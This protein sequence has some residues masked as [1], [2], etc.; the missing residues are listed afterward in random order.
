MAGH[1]GHF[2]RRELL[3][4]LGVAAAFGS[5][6][7]WPGWVRAQGNAGEK[8]AGMAQLTSSAGG[9][10]GTSQLFTLDAKV[11]R[12]SLTKGSD[13]GE[14]VLQALRNIEDEIWASIGDKKR[15]LIKPNFVST[16]RELAASHPD[17]IRVILDFLK[18]RY[19]HE[20]IVGEAAAGRG[21]TFEG[22]WNFSYLPLEKEYGVKLVDLNQQP[23]VYRYVF[24]SGHKPV[25]IRIISTFLDPDIY[26]I[27]AARMKTHDRVV[28][29]L[30][31]KNT[32]LGAPVND[33]RKNDKSLTHMENSFTPQAVLHF[34]MFHL[35]Q[36]IYPDLGVIDGFVGMEG[37]GPVGGTPVESRVAL[38]SLD[39]PARDTLTTKLT[40]FDPTKILYL[41]S[42]AEAG[43]GQGDLTKVH[44]IGTPVEQCQFKFKP[45]ERLLES[46]GSS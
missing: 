26:I 37:N 42:M 19:K 34:N 43:M 5:P 8:T 30:S 25:A 38:A 40:G 33:G 21:G 9:S 15:I 46:Y 6:G 4:D 29:T 36:E 7:R 17:E 35:A 1:T 27:S 44:V 11:S 31:L 16:T 41:S 23:W 22:Y 12:V 28:T 10:G 32:V 3:R 13:R 20:T 45:H 2:N 24:G 18:P 39:P 14:I